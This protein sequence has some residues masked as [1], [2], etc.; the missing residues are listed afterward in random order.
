MRAQNLL[1]VGCLVAAGMLFSPR[2]AAAQIIR[3]PRVVVRGTVVA[4][5]TP[6]PL[7]LT[8]RRTAT[9]VI[10]RRPLLVTQPIDQ[11]PIIAVPRRFTNRTYSRAYRGYSTVVYPRGGGSYVI[12]E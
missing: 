12:I 11:N 5:I 8:P 2:D 10:V 7:L 4:P 1:I 9:R 3:T 6:Q